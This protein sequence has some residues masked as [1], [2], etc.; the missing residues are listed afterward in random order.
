MSTPD[1]E[2]VSTTKA[3]TAELLHAATEL[4]ESIAR[5]RGMLSSLSIEERTR[6]LTAAADVFDPDPVQRRRYTKA[7]RKEERAESIRADEAKLADTGIRVLREKPVFT[8]PNVYP[9]KE[10]RAGGRG[11]RDPRDDRGAALLRLQGPLPRAPSLLRPDVPT[12]CGVQLRQALRDRRP[13][14]PRRRSHRWAREDRLPGRDQAAPRRGASGRDHALPTR[15]GRALRA[16]AG[17][18]RVERPA[19]DLRSRPAAHA[20]ASRRSATTCRRRTTGSTT[21]STTPARPSAGRPT[22]IAT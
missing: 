14:G 2:D 7:K 17:L 11:R 20:R 1:P 10:L 16:G 4:L 3:D 12:L 15:L 21:S 8:T 6:L 5:D 13:R 9:P 18:R 22:S 19:R